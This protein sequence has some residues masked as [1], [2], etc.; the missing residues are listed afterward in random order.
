MGFLDRFRNTSTGTPAG[1]AEDPARH[2]GEEAHP[3]G[4]QARLARALLEYGLVGD[5]AHA[6]TAGQTYAEALQVLPRDE[7]MRH[8]LQLV[9]WIERQQLSTC[10]LLPFF[11]IETD[12]QI[13][14]TAALHAAPVWPGET[15]DDPL[16]GVRALV[17]KAWEF[18]DTGREERA[19]AILE[20][21]LLLG[22]PRVTGEL[23]NC[24][25]ELSPDGRRS[26]AS[27][28]GVRAYGPV[29]DWLI[30][31]LEDCEGNEFGAVAWS[32]TQ[33]A[34]QA[35]SYGVVEV[36]RALPIW[37]RPIEEA[38]RH[39]NEWTFAEFGALI[40]GR[41]RN[42]ADNE[43][44][45]RLM[46][47]V[48]AAWELEAYVI[49]AAFRDGAG[50]IARNAECR[51]LLSLI[52]ADARLASHRVPAV[53]LAERE[54]L[55]HGGQLLLNWGIFN[56]YGPTWN[57][58][59]LVDTEDPEV[60]LLFY[61]MLNP[62]RQ[63]TVAIHSIVG[64]DRGNG[65]LIAS[66]LDGLLRRN[67]IGTGRGDGEPLYL[68]TCAPSFVFAAPE[69]AEVRDACAGWFIHSPGVLGWNDLEAALGRLEQYWGDPWARAGAERDAAAQRVARSGDDDAARL[70][71]VQLDPYARIEL[72]AQ[73]WDRVL[74]PY[75][76]V[77][78]VVAFAKA[79]ESVLSWYRQVSVEAKDTPNGT[80]A[81]AMVRD[82][83]PLD[84]LLSFQERFKFPVL[85]DLWRQ[86]YE[87]RGG[88]SS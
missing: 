73:W 16:C 21:L 45:P 40:A 77:A 28:E 23:R 64:K 53:P 19:V 47:H 58:L 5:E 79:W 22:D 6:I 13:V 84:A 15:E 29:I 27:L 69:I 20:G 48:L 74:E 76:W 31:W 38:A 75:H 8:L 82:A 36:D 71:T 26:L 83:Y 80:I 50:R 85:A 30:E 87:A 44:E 63:D 17:A 25:R 52:P 70:P 41:L 66:C 65:A 10:A 61:R 2:E 12:P 78:E 14:A 88:A 59:G 81:A 35:K 54:L 43:S 3:E 33:M 24:W 37:S 49:P 62:F 72:A 4:I 39:T 18:R 57:T 60:S 46:H 34:Q 1:R 42:I 56:P 68:V 86:A 11:H 7:R 32:L 55:A 51:E 67:L 9:E